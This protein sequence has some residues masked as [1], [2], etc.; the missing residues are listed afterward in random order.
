MHTFPVKKHAKKQ[1]LSGCKMFKDPPSI[2]DNS[3]ICSR[4]PISF[5]GG[6]GEKETNKPI[7]IKPLVFAVLR[8]SDSQ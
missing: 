3:L 4:Q 5:H 6:F 1:M 8:G 7:E 2:K